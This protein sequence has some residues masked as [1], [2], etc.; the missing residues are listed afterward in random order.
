M[1]D[2]TLAYNLTTR[3]G[4]Y[5]KQWSF[6]KG[7][8]TY[9]RNFTYEGLPAETEKVTTINFEWLST[10]YQ[11]QTI[12]D[13]LKSWQA[14]AQM[15]FKMFNQNFQQAYYGANLYGNYTSDAAKTKTTII[16]DI[17]T[18]TTQQEIIYADI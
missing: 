16:V 12:P 7:V 18:N 8:M 11:M 13:W 4:T 1:E 6:D 9:G 5:N 3:V 17:T 10:Y 15:S 14:M 2:P